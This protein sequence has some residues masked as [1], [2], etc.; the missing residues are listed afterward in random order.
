MEEDTR[1]RRPEDTRHS[2]YKVAGPLLSLGRDIPGIG[3]QPDEL[4][5]VTHLELSAPHALRVTQH[6]P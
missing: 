2:G 5:H 4:D 6:G 1:D 3:Q